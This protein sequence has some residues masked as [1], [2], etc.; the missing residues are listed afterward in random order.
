MTYGTKSWLVEYF[1]AGLTVGIIL[2]NVISVRITRTLKAKTNTIELVLHNRNGEALEGG[3]IKYKPDEVIKVYAANGDV[4]INNPYHLIGTYQ[5]QDGGLNAD[6][7]VVTLKG[8]DKT[9]NMLAK[10][11]VGDETAPANEIIEN[12][13][14]TINENGL[15]TQSIVTHIAQTKSDGTSFPV[16][17]YTSVYKTAYDAITELSQINYTGDNREYIFWFDENNEFWW[18]YPNNDPP[19]ETFKL[20]DNNIIS[21][22]IEKTESETISMVIYN[23]GNDLNG[24]AWLG[25]YF[26]PL[27]TS[28]KNRMLY[29]PMTDISRDLYTKLEK[30]GKI[31]TITNEEYVALLDEAA[32]ARA[33]AIISKV[34]QGLWE[35]NITVR[36]QKFTPG[37]IY[38]VDASKLGLSVLN[39]R[40]TRVVH[41]MN[42]NGWNTQLNLKEDPEKL[43]V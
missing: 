20:S 24:N 11:Y 23:A 36:G 22:K 40:L 15:T 12:I 37:S 27:A 25:F 4:D 2:K 17:E 9:Y 33:R 32:Q 19:A 1:P 28:F 16:K 21:M 35:A 39:L 34:G 10:L 38:G 6:E 26:D 3:V 14:Q 13:V 18:I 8:I 41:T 29:Q 42:R 7:N 43:E 30:E 5:I 31:G